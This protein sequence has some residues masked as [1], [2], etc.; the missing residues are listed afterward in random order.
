MIAISLSAGDEL[1][2]VRLTSGRDD[3]LL[4]T[5]QGQALR[6]KETEI[7]TMGRQAAGVTSIKLRPGDQLAA[8]EVVQPEGSLLIVTENGYGKRVALSAYP[9]RRRATTG[10]MTI[11]RKSIKQ[12]GKIVA[13]RVVHKNDEVTVI[14][15][16][17]I[18]LRLKVKGISQM[19]RSTRG[20]RLMDLG[21]SDTVASLGRISPS[22]D[23]NGN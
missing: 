14:S 6:I 16:A 19:G 11:D 2:W 18:V 21:E 4:V 3:L 23:E 12:I 10:V 8:M 17:G 22:S 5:A 1:G 20:V 7:R 15:T 9:V 13:A